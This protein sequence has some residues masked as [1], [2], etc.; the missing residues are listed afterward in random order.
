MKLE[1][2]VSKRLI[3]P[4]RRRTAQDQEPGQPAITAREVVRCGR[5]LVLRAEY[6]RHIVN[7]GCF[8]IA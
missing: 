8:R 4:Y 3:A 5:V 2:I 6:R 1:G 7:G